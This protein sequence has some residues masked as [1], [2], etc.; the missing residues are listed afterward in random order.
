MSQAPNQ[1]N[2]EASEN[3]IVLK[4]VEQS[5]PQEESKEAQNSH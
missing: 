1:A 5:D 2:E 4:P 3:P